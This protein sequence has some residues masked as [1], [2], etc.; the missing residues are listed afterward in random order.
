VKAEAAVADQA[1]AAVESFQA[2]VGQAEGDRGEDALAVCPDR[3]CELDER[4]E[5]AAGGPGQ[6]GVEVL[7]REHRVL[8]L[9]DQPEFLFEQEAAVERLVGLLD[10]VKQRELADRLLL[11]ALE[12]RP[13]GA[14]DPLAGLGV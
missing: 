7:G 3:A 4:L 9:V 1:V 10:L 6:P 11:G 13:A 12:Q 14:F 2:P 8:E 5:L